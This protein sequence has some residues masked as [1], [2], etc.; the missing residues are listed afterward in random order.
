M[1]PRKTTFNPK[2]KEIYPWILPAPK[3]NFAA[4]CKYCNKSFSIAGK[5]EGCVK[6]HAQTSK[7]KEAERAAT[8]S[9]SLDRFFR[10]C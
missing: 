2:W 10:E 5:G 8:S 7:H 9:K 4:Y 3:D 1:G 6:E